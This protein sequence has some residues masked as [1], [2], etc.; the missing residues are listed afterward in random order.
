MIDIRSIPIFLDGSDGSMWASRDTWEECI[1][2]RG[3]VA[4]RRF[5]R[6]DDIL[7][8]LEANNYAF[9]DLTEL[10]QLSIERENAKK[11]CD[12]EATAVEVIDPS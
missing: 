3:D 6:V 5:A 8:W 9:I 7:T 12:T 4:R 11:L 2:H 10:L 1:A